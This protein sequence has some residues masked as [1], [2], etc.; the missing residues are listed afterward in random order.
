[1]KKALLLL[2]VL[3]LLVSCTPKKKTCTL[4]ATKQI[5][6]PTAMKRLRLEPDPSRNMDD[7]TLVKDFC[8]AV[9][10]AP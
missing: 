1:M 9:W 10:G 3:F 5:D 8:E 4:V 2:P 6:Y 7:G